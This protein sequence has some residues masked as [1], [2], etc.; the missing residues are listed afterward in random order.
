MRRSLA[1]TLVM[2][3]VALPAAL[4]AQA[5]PGGHAQPEHELGVDLGVVYSHIGSGCSQSCGIFQVVTPVDVRIGF[6]GR[7]GTSVEPRFSV[8]WATGSGGHSLL[9]QPDINVLLPTGKRTGMLGEYVTFG[10]GLKYFDVNTGLGSTSATQFSVN[11][12]FG[13]R[14]AWGSGAFRPELTLVYAFENNNFPSAI[15]IGVRL[16]LSLWH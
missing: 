1:T 3:G 6:I 5:M 10:A 12:G 13:D 2:A 9:L 14:S 8:A 7:G 11:G 16:G 4:R 15:S